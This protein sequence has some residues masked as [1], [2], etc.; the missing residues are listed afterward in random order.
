MKFFVSIF[1]LALA[2]LSLLAPL[3]QAQALRAEAFK[4]QWD[5]TQTLDGDTRWLVVSQSMDAGD[6]VKET[7]EK[8]DL[9]SPADHGMLYLADVSGMPGLVTKFFALPAMRDYAF[10]MALIRA[11]DELAAM[12]LPITS[13]EAVT[14]LALESLDVVDVLM[15]DDA[16]AFEVFLNT[17]VLVAPP[18]P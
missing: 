7:F 11:E 12:K 17:R 3:S 15:F 8:L 4:D 16:A 2:F 13:E 6:I 1:L 10:P 9:A 5:N 14:V 18:N